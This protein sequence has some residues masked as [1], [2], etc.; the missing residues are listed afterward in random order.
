MNSFRLLEDTLPDL[1]AM[2]SR[3]IL[4]INVILEPLYP[5]YDLSTNFVPFIPCLPCP[6]YRFSIL[7]SYNFF[8]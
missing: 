1:S 3:G 5:L 4:N 6:H 8:R 7:I 2:D